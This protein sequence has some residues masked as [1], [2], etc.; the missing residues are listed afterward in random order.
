MDTLP[1]ILIAAVTVG[2]LAFLA[3]GLRSRTTEL[4]DDET[5]KDWGLQAEIEERGAE[6]RPR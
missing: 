5:P 6:Q 1:T 4:P 3:I 2:A